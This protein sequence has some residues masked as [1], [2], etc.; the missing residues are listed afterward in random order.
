[1]TRLC[2]FPPTHPCA[3]VATCVLAR[4]CWTDDGDAFIKARPKLNAYWDRMRRRPSFDKAQVWTGL[5][6]GRIF[7][8]LGDMV[9]GA[10]RTVGSFWH[11]A[12][13]HPVQQTPGARATRGRG[14]GATD[15]PSPV[16]PLHSFA[17][18]S[19]FILVSRLSVLS[20]CSTTC[21]IPPLFDL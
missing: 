11:D 15:P 6:L 3:V 18:R 19:Q 14:G 5:R 13:V 8:V 10:V 7:C 9:S 20:D 12:V 4:S 1:M 16:S 21:L 17:S 2:L